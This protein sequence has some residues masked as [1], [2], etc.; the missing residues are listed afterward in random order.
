MATKRFATTVSAPKGGRIYVSG[1][2]KEEFETKL[3]EVRMQV[4]CGIDVSAAGKTTF[5]E[6]AELWLA[7]YKAP[8][9]VRESSY[10]LIRYNI[11]KYILPFFGSMLLRDITPMHVQLFLSGIS[12]LSRSVQS[13][14]LQ[15]V[16]AVFSTAVE[17]NLIVKSPVSSQS[18]ITGEPA[19]ETTALTNDQAR[20]LLDAVRGTRAYL[21][22]LIALST[23][24]R[25]GEIIGLKWE[26][27]DFDA[28]VINVTHNKSFLNNANDAPV[29][30][31][32]KTE[33][34][35]RRL[36]ISDTLYAELR[37]AR[38]TSNSDFV[39]SML[40][41]RSLTKGA[42]RAMWK[43][44]EARTATDKHPLG[45]KIQGCQFGATTVTLNFSCHPHQLRHTFCTQCIEA[46]MAVK[47]VQYLMGHAT[48]EMT[49][50]V[51]A[52]YRQQ[53][54]EAETAAQ[55]NSVTSYLA[56]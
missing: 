50:R 3:A 19:K 33:T 28:R 54:L 55:L 52:H 1:R 37:A 42:F 26:D 25:R 10:N 34:A 47:Q 30:T 9:R 44:V 46:G 36:P 38:E 45:S 15:T 21:F 31:M 32:L 20:A 39:V 49:M 6:Y 53:S 2:T 23:G 43:I 40:D 27:I 22:C 29:T 7:A 35:R 24:M 16:K 51:Y 18:K 4:S 41:G 11:E 8:P 56:G 12:H 17:N 48:P 13:K 14:C 5:G